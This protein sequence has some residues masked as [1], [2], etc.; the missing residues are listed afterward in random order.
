M[1]LLYILKLILND[2][3][4]LFHVGFF[5]FFSLI[6]NENCSVCVFMFNFI[7]ILFIVPCR[8]IQY[9]AMLTSILNY[10]NISLNFVTLPIPSKYIET[11]LYFFH[12]LSRMVWQKVL[13]DNA[14]KRE[15]Q[16][17][18]FITLIRTIEVQSL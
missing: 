7:C 2:P 17:F 11:I 3:F 6:I 1:I 13:W 10:Y 4:V 15:C 16:C 5:W 14:P 8:K 12:I 18:F 9:Y